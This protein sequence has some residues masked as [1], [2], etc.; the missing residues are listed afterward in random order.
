[1]TLP[2]S[3]ASLNDFPYNWHT[4]SWNSDDGE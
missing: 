2:V 3:V 1:M 4:V